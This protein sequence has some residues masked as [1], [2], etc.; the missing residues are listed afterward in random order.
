MDFE[1]AFDVVVCGAGV[2]GVAA[3][4]ECARS[5]LHTALVEKTV[6]VGGLATTG[7]VNVYLPLCD[8][9]GR[10]VIYGI[11]EELLRL[12]L[13][14]GPGDIPAGWPDG[15][16]EQRTARYQTPFS[17]A[18]FIL[19]LDEAL[20]DAG[21]SI[22]LDTLI[23]RPVLAGDA[24]VGVEV[25]DKSGRGLLRAAIV[26]DATGDADIAYRSGAPCVDGVNYLSLWALHISAEDLRK[27][28]ESGNGL[29]LLKGVRVGGD[30]FGSG[31]PAG[32]PRLH[33]TEGD[34]VTQFVLDSRK[35]LRE[36][37]RSRQG[38]S[39][40]G[41]RHNLFPITLPSMAQF[42]TT[43]HI[44]GQATLVDGQANTH[45]A[46]SVGLSGDW[47]QRG[48]VW[49]IPYGTLVPQHVQGLLAAGRCISAHGEA[50]EVTRVIPAAALTGQV[51]GVAA[52]LALAA[53]MPPHA[54]AAGDVQRELARLGIPFHIADV[55]TP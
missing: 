51:A 22:L 20:L 18:S 30:A 45:F 27:A 38:E 26:I 42:R 11:A 16:Q 35:L 44:A 40:A 32:Y 47:R 31:H 54:L 29:P 1:K 41:D 49:E 48:P 4:L 52:R 53:H 19:A 9:R 8:G 7:L 36:Y 46:D 25:E 23:C 43:R 37:Y 10:Q 15:P 14:Y 24:I 12:S 39:N 5:G 21:V 13:K 33:G 28:L 2:A 50:W 55:I 17:P 34:D 6:L 3:A